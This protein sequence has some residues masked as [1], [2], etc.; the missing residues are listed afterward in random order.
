VSPLSSIKGLLNRRAVRLFWRLWL[1]RRPHRQGFQHRDFPGVDI[2]EVGLPGRPYS[3]TA[4][5]AV[6]R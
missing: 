5:L 1:L 4:L 6:R 2:V 3:L